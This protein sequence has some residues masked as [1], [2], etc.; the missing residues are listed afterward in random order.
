MDRIRR[1]T[2]IILLFMLVTAALTSAVSADGIIPG[3]RA[4][5]EGNQVYFG[6]NNGKPVLWRVMG[7]GNAGSGMLLLSEYLLDR[8][9]FNQDHYDVNANVW[10]YSLAQIWCMGFYNG[11]FT[12]AEQ[13]SVIETSKYDTAY[14]SKHE[15]AFGTSSL[16]NEF[17]F[18]LSA[19]E[20]ETYFPRDDD[21]SRK[22]YFEKESNADWWWLRSP[23]A[24]DTSFAGFV[25]DDGWVHRMDVYHY[26]GARPAFNL[27][28][29][30]ILFSSRI[31]QSEKQYKLTLLDQDL[32]ISLSGSGE[33]PFLLE[34]ELSVDYKLSGDHAGPNTKA[35]ILI[36]DKAWGD[37]D[38]EVLQYGFLSG[39][40]PFELDP[41][42]CGTS[43]HIY[44]TAVNENGEKTSAYASEPVELFPDIYHKV[45]VTTD[46]N[47]TASASPEFGPEG[48]EMSLTAVPNEGYEFDQWQV[49]S[50][51]VSIA[52]DRFII[53]TSDVEIKA[54]FKE[55]G[56]EPSY[57]V[58]MTTDGN[59][60][61]SAS[62]ISGPEG[63]EVSLTAVPNEGYEFD[64]W[65]VISG[66]VSIV[67]DK[68]TIGTADV[69]IRA[70][71][72]KIGGKSYRLNVDV[73]H[74]RKEDGGRGIPEEV[75]TT[76]ASVLIR[77]RDEGFESVSKEK[78]ELD[79]S[80]GKTKES[81]TLEFSKEIPDPVPGAYE[82]LVE[83]L[84]KTVKGREKI[85]GGIPEEIEFNLTWKAQLNKKGGI[86]I[87]IYWENAANAW[88]PEVIA[89][90]PLPEDEIG[91]YVLH[92]D[93]TKEYLVFHTYPICM[94]YLGSDELCRGYERCYHK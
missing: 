43:Y 35:L 71:F 67:K 46:G 86:T 57:K 45:T 73:F 70:L 3:A 7:E 48:T 39:S 32:V 16:V 5:T 1:L 72:K 68:F 20:A 76:S 55:E 94:S 52:N 34:N 74:I 77:V 38:A 6:S 87:Y 9:Q 59:G 85:H 18:F 19:E 30:S 11:I 54:L 28:L 58:T 88:Q 21:G 22:A 63:T 60:T 51:G 40:D 64:Q 8:T 90:Y 49:I 91:S 44:L 24:S 82:V 81:F 66:G 53:G 89:V 36:T 33:K 25:D 56:I 41:E 61:A 17:V 83:G 12:L 15:V 29:T 37:P 2:N 26:Y 69:E 31:P 10:Q 50:G 79:L 27:N 84:P 80:A 13:S 92:D 47:G 4:V 65:Q 75:I 42:K 14:N 23:H 62:P 78:A 93:G